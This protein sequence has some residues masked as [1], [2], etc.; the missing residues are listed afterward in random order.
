MAALIGTILLAM[1]VLGVISLYVYSEGRS[2]ARVGRYENKYRFGFE[3][4][5]EA[6]YKSSDDVDKRMTK[7]KIKFKQH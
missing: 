1:I 3:Y 4:L 6:G 2:A 5:Y 7:N